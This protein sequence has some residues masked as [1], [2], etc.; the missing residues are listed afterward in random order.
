MADRSQIQKDIDRLKAENIDLKQ[1]IAYMKT[2]SKKTLEDCQEELEKG[3]DERQTLQ[4][5]VRRL[6]DANHRIALENSQLKQKPQPSSTISSKALKIK[7]LS[8]DGNLNS[9]RMMKKRLEELACETDAIGLAPR[10][11][12]K[13]TTLYVKAGCEKEGQLL[14]SGLGDNTVMRPLTWSSI[15]DIIIVTGRMP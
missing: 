8:G 4:E 7:V 9:A 2:V 5:E 11:D 3:K 15:F 6:R 14:A 10:S 13:K 1:Q 12:F